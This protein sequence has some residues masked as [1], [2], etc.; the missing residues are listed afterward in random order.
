MYMIIPNVNLINIVV[1][2]SKMDKH[3]M[4]VSYLKCV[5]LKVYGQVIQLN[6]NVR[7]KQEEK[8]QLNNH[9]IISAKK[10]ALNLLRT[11]R[12]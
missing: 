9:Q 8:L 6:I 7:I 1:N 11:S 12:Y 3:F 5:I 4:G 10:N 2:G